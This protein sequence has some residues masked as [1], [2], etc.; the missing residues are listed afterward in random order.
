AEKILVVFFGN[1]RHPEVLDKLRVSYRHAGFINDARVVRDIL[2]ASKVIL[3][4]SLYETL[5]GTLVEGQAAG[6]IPVCFADDGR[7]DVVTHK[8]NGYVARRGDY[9][10]I[11]N[12]I[13]WALKSGISRES[14]HKSVRDRF[15]SDV[16][17]ARYIKLFEEIIDR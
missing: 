16:I 4:T 14:L 17:A 6:A 11:A 13:L 7:R 8:V 2:A 1:I 10:D 15:S 3:S 5:G 9:V 12:G